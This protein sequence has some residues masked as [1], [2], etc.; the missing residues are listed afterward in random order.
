MKKTILAFLATLTFNMSFLVAQDSMSEAQRL[1]SAAQNS[2][3]HLAYSKAITA[4][5][6]AVADGFGEAAYILGDIYLFG[7]PIA[8]GKKEDGPLAFE[9]YKKGLELG[10]EKGEI[11]LGRMCLYGWGIER[12]RELAY[13]Y[14]I[15]A[16][17]RGLKEGRYFVALCKWL[18][19]G[20]ESTADDEDF[21]VDCIK[22]YHEEM[23]KSYDV[24]IKDMVA[25][26]LVNPTYRDYFNYNDWQSI[27][28]ACEIWYSTGN[29]ICMM[30]TVRYMYVQKIDNIGYGNHEYKVILNTLDYLTDDKAKAEAYYIYAN[31]VER[32]E[33]AGGSND[34]YQIQY[35]NTL[36]KENAMMKAAELGYPLALR[37]LANW[38]RNGKNVS[39]NLVMANK[40]QEKADAVQEEIEKEITKFDAYSKIE[41][42]KERATY[43]GG[44]EALSQYIRE[45]RVSVKDKNGNDVSGRASVQIVVG[46]DG[47]IKGARILECDHPALGKELLRLVNGMP[48]FIPGKKDGQPVW[49]RQKISCVL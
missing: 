11:N 4:L 40:W 25:E 42:V 2:G 28:E 6:K 5:N 47:S 33:D 31:T 37:D 22:K 21:I 29:S 14:F 45:N 12:D 36:T 26:Y 39:K 10:Y 35:K 32:I 49:T 7:Y 3:S 1:Y 15:K 27:K 43:P 48:L 16:M 38:Y 46:K 44:R 8:N 9:M 17:K 19:W 34:Y 20:V 41:D 18:G 30:E 13:Q 23:S 24:V